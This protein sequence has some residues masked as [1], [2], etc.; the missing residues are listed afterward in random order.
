MG[1]MDWI[2]LTKYRDRWQAVVNVVMNLWV[3]WNAG[4]FLTSLEPVSLSRR[5]LL[6]G[7][8]LIGYLNVVV[9]KVTNRLS[10]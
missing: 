1:V 9:H 10:N 5:P 8:S 2:N 4:N 6:H 3:L 7:V